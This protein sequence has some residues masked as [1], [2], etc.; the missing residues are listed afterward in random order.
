[1][2]NIIRESSMI[3]SSKNTAQEFLLIVNAAKISEDFAWLH[4]HRRR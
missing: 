1:M 2:L 3:S 4:I